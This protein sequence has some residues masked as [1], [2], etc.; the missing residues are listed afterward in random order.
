MAASPLPAVVTTVL[1]DLDDTLYP[2]QAWLDGAWRSV[3][4]AA[5]EFDVP[6][7]LLEHE[8]R[9]VAAE[10]SDRGRI[11]DRALEAIDRADVDVAPLVEAFLAH[12]PDR[13]SPYPGAAEAL[14][15]LADT[16][17][18]AIVTDG[19]GPIQR[20]KIEVLGLEPFIHHVVVSDDM[21]REHRK[22]SPASLQ[23]AMAMLAGHVRETVMI[24][25]RPSKDVV[26]ARRAGVA[27]IRVRTGEY[28]A[29]VDEPRA[30]A[31]VE[32]FAAAAELVLGTTSASRRY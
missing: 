10:G 24:G 14:K 8:L 20:H 18:V 12:R 4:A 2:Q 30:D 3:A 19:L 7:L 31:I 28:R 13:L 25:D 6:P 22:P 21:G 32:D 29:H 17:Q 27:A 5:A 23:R 15:E 9:R 1:V 16:R 26:A 11:I